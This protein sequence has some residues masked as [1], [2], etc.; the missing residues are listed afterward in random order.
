MDAM[1]L[2][3]RFRGIRVAAAAFV[4]AALTSAVPSPCA[5]CGEPDPLPSHIL[6]LG[7][8]TADARWL[9]GPEAAAA[10]PAG[11]LEGAR[12]GSVALW[13]E[14]A[15]DGARARIFRDGL[16]DLVRHLCEVACGDEEGDPALA[17]AGLDALPAA[18]DGALLPLALGYSG[19]TRRMRDEALD[20]LAARPTRE[21]N[22]ALGV[23]ALEGARL[24]RERALSV[25]DQPGRRTPDIVLQA[26]RDPAA[27]DVMRRTRDPRA[28]GAIVHEILLRVSGPFQRSV[29]L[30]ATQRAYVRDF[31]IVTGVETIGADPEIGYVQA[32]AVTDVKVASVQ[33][34]YDVLHHLTG[35]AFSSPQEVLEWWNLHRDEFVD[36]LG[37]PK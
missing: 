37:N 9:P 14:P 24:A 19:G 30:V 35:I 36:D 22:E 33:Q 20:R 11:A 25:F 29:L 4:A 28:V 8:D 1:R 16:G 21:A 26:V 23:V 2:L 15:A 5:I 31:T 34:Y 18:A 32:G 10:L 13:I 12:E 6:V 7:A 3:N 27:H 17:R